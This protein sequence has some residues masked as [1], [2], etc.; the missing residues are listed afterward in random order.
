M[1]SKIFV[2]F[3]FIIAL[4]GVIMSGCSDDNGAKS[5]E[6][7]FTIVYENMNTGLAQNRESLVNT[8]AEWEIIRGDGDTFTELDAKINEY[9][10]VANSLIVYAFTRNWVGLKA[11]VTEISRI[12]NELVVNVTHIDGDMAI[13]AHGVII[14]EVAKEDITNVSSLRIV[15]SC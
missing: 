13:P 3:L 7:Y 2:T 6:I 15:S 14:I 5:Q 12:W 11:E 4:M 1:K 10:F 8:F 9:F